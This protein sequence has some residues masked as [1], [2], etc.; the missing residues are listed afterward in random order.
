M[1]TF[2]REYTEMMVVTAALSSPPS[3][4][5]TYPFFMVENILLTAHYY[6]CVINNHLLLMTWKLRRLL[7]ENSVRSGS[8]ALASS[9]KST[10]AFLF[11]PFPLPPSSLLHQP[12][13]E[14][15]NYILEKF[16]YIRK[17]GATMRCRVYAYV[18]SRWAYFEF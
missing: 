15:E 18:I 10:F 3:P 8:F 16:G 17:Q 7:M 4:Q 6:V 9:I 14:W 5:M 2:K 12:E 11:S 13:L 1:N